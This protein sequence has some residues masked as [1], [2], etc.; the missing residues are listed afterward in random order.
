V[1][2]VRRDAYE[3]LDLPDVSIVAEDRERVHLATRPSRRG[4]GGPVPLRAVVLLHEAGDV[5]TFERIPPVDAVQQLWVLAFNLPTDEGRARCFGDLVALTEAVP[6]WRLS[7]PFSY[8]SLAD[9]VSSVA[10]FFRA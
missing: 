8:Q 6:V 4:D 7:R 3:Q 2:K 10:D 1:L 9:V 5:P